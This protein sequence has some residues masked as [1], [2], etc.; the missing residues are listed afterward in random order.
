MVIERGGFH[1]QQE[2][3]KEVEITKFGQFH[4][5]DRVLIDATVEQEFTFNLP[6]IS[7][8]GIEPSEPS[9][10]YGIVVPKKIVLKPG[11][12]YVDDGQVQVATEISPGVPSGISRMIPGDNLT[13]LL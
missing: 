11:E 5:G 9:E 13:K 2:M 4:V 8:V 1:G 3:S 12:S 7:N 6:D 10:T